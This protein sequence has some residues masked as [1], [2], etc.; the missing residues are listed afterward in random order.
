MLKGAK[1]GKAQHTNST[2]SRTGFTAPKFENLLRN[3]ILKDILS[4]PPFEMESMILFL[5]IP[6]VG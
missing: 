6:S 5:E 4:H 1:I 2:S 3:I